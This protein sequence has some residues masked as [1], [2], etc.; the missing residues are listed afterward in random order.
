MFLHIQIQCI[1]HSKTTGFFCI[2]S[3]AQMVRNP[4]AMWET[5]IL[6]L[7]RED[8]LEKGMATPSS[9]LIKE[10]Q[11]MELHGLDYSHEVAKSQTRLSDFHFSE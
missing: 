11:S 3:V 8:P 6:S 10:F 5:Q 9:I 2:A 4:P 1:T 7:G